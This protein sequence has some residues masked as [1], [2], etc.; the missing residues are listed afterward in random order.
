MLIYNRDR[1]FLDVVA[2]AGVALT[3]YQITCP[4]KPLTGN[5]LSG[6]GLRNVAVLYPEKYFAGNV[7]DIPFRRK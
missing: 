4:T 1:K 3:S 7:R 2:A 5:V 6:H